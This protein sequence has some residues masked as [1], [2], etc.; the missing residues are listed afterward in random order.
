M[1]GY[2]A[3]RYPR[4]TS[5]EEDD[6]GIKVSSGILK[7]MERNAFRLIWR[8]YDVQGSVFGLHGKVF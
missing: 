8:V 2:S 5:L 6:E 4:Y 3:I 1:R 7:T